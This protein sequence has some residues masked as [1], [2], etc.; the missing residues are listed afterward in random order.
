VFG[1]PDAIGRAI[2][3]ISLLVHLLSVDGED[4]RS[5]ASLAHL[6]GRLQVGGQMD[7]VALAFEQAVFEDRGN[8]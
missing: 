1:K 5:A 4:D 3:E 8:P 7:V 2:E 6:G